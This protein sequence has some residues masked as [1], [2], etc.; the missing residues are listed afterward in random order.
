[1]NRVLKLSLICTGIFIAGGVSGVLDTLRYNE[2]KREARRANVDSFGPS[3]MRRFSEALDLSEEQRAQLRPILDETGEELRKLRRE[4]YRS[5]AALTAQ[6]E[7]RMAE[8]LTPEQ[9]ERLVEMQ[10]EQ[11]DRLR[12]RLADYGRKR[13]AGDRDRGAPRPPPPPPAE[14]EP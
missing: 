3:Q 4:S 6:M 9:R 10:S 11:R 13:D 2:I 1:M 12:K 5:F 8:I 7:A 14:G